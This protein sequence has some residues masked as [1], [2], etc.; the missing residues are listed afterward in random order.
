MITG[1]NSDVRYRRLSFH[2]QTE[3]KGPKN[4]IVETLLYHKGMI[5]ASR[6][7]PYH[8]ILNDDLVGEKVKKLMIKQHQE[9]IM[10]LRKGVFDELILG[11]K[12]EEKGEEDIEKLFL[13]SIEKFKRISLDVEK[14]SIEDIYLKID[15]VVNSASLEPVEGKFIEIY[16]KLPDGKRMFL[17]KELTDENGKI[18]ISLLAPQI[19][20][21]YIVIVS[22]E[23]K[24]VGR[25][26]KWFKVD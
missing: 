23:V 18:P 9:M 15:A 20:K 17:A 6:K 22:V 24:E 11:S 13:E 10:D 4:P 5:L 26:E 7:T 1:Y 3:D 12:E 14:F 19:E 25:D 8:H 16:L 2:V 21:P